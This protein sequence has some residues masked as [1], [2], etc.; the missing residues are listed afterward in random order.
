MFS[1]ITPQERPAVEAFV[2][3]GRIL[4]ILRKQCSWD[5]VQT[6]ASLRYLT[7]EEVYELSDAILQLDQSGSDADSNGELKKE[8]GDIF[9]HLMF[10]AK[11]ADDEHRFTLADVLHSIGDK[12][13]S[14]HPHI[15]LP[16]R[17]GTMQ[18]GPHNA[19]PEWEKVKMKEGRRSVLEGVPSSTPSLVK[20][21]RM[22][23]KAMGVGFRFPSGD[24]AL[25]KVREEYQELVDAIADN[26]A[27]PSENHQAHVVE[28]FGDLMFA[29]TVWSHFIGVNADEALSLA[30][31]KFKSRFTYVESRAASQGTTVDQLSLQDMRA[32]WKEA[33]SRE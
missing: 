32:L 6:I 25:G 19:A 31:Q 18:G 8:L 5:S 24:E 29:L 2:R 3:L 9:M 30:N 13:V 26:E 10:Y 4:D 15:S 33:K 22:Q 7:I 16:D 1:D 20:A 11:I 23:E 14:R 21:Q 12:L 17:E 27:A 28:E